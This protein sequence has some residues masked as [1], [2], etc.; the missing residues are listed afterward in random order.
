MILY[1]SLRL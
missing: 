1:E